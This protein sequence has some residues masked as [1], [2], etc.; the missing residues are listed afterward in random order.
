[1]VKF[2]DIAKIRLGYSFREKLEEDD[3]GNLPII[4]FKDLQSCIFENADNCLRLSADKIKPSH[5]LKYGEI[6]LSNRGNYK[7]AVNYCRYPCVASGVF[8]VLTVQ[9]KNFLP[10]YVA[11]FL[12][13]QEGQKSLTKHHN[14]SGVN[15]INR[16]ELEQIDIPLLPLEKQKQLVELFLLYEKEVD[17]FEKL[18][19]SRKK[20][21][22]SILSQ[23]IKE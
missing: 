20:L 23:T 17:I 14:I 8:F 7:A 2:I 6:L 22:N 3:E 5:W 19:Q 1:M 16:A 18:K 4:Q 10:E 12:N 15:S 9:D 21:I 13:S 11:A